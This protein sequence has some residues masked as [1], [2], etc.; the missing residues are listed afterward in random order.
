EYLKQALSAYTEG[1]R[2]E[3]G[4]PQDEAVAVMSEKFEILL[5]LLHGFDLSRFDA[6]SPKERL[7]NLARMMEHVS[8][9]HDGIKRFVKAVGDISKAFALAVPH[10]DAL[11]I[12]ERV[13]Y[14]Q[15]VRAAFMKYTSGGGGP[16]QEDLDAA[17]R[18][19]V[20]QA[21]STVEVMDVFASAGLNKPEIS[22]LSD[23]FLD[24]VKKL[25][26]RNLALELLRKLINDEIKN[27]GRKNLVQARSFADMLEKAIHQYQNRTIDAAQVI[28]ELIELAKQMRASRERGESLGLTEDE[29]A[30]YDALGV[31]DS[32]VQVLGDETLK[33]IARELSATI[34]KNV[35]IDWTQKDSVRAKLRVL[36]KRL[37]NKYGYP[38][39]KQSLATQTVLDQAEV[40]AKDW[41]A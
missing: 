26:Q 31:N 5:G 16:T 37:L 27:R 18:Q 4:V 35:T 33:I 1:D 22:L 25:P 21:V 40:I 32:A 13:A 29:E 14:F 20:S 30:F 15:A 19:L 41:V 3:A 17:V 2:R 6:W 34:R 24:E 28:A 8:A 36:V 11:A 38:P 12:R 23:E 10:E 9:Q 39:D 7:A